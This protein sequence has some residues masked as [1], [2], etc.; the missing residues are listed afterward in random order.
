M[1]C[2][3]KWCLPGEP[4][5]DFLIL[6]ALSSLHCPLLCSNSSTAVMMIQHRLIYCLVYC[7]SSELECKLQVQDTLKGLVTSISV[8][9]GLLLLNE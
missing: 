4:T 8:V 6:G 5:A 2:P 9:Q 3:L 7:L 1:W